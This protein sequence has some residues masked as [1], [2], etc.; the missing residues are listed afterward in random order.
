MSTIDLKTLLGAAIKTER[1]SLRISQEELA[2]RA[3]LHRTYVSDLERGTRNPSVDSIGKLARA[4]QVSVSRLF[5]QAGDGN[6]SKPTIEILLVEDNSHD[7]DL[8]THA[9]KRAR[10]A[11]PL[12]VARD[13]VEALDFIFARGRY[14][15]RRDLRLPGLI[16]L[17]LDLPKMSGL[18]VLQEVKADPVTRN[19]PVIILTVSSRDRDINACRRLGA[20]HYIIKP[21][22][23]QNFSALTARLSLAWVLIKP[24]ADIVAAVLGQNES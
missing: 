10:I 12:H 9:F 1:T 16:L 7:V 20:D 5:E 8:T 4:L 3:G 17:D 13:G 22:G 11:N 18:D 24:A 14:A 15:H 6:S 19:I 21:V 2:H 23:F